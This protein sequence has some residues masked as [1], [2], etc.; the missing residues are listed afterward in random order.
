MSW[1]K[2]FADE[3]YGYFFK[4]DP[5]RRGIRAS[6]AASKICITRNRKGRVRRADD[7]FQNGSHL[8][9]HRCFSRSRREA[10][11]SH[12]LRRAKKSIE[13]RGFYEPVWDAT[14]DATLK[15]FP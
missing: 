15:D 13:D 9:T 1:K 8:L 4:S 5:E 11:G 12:R 2:S 3:I 7:G 14:L 10:H 6:A